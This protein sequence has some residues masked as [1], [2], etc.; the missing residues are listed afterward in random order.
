[1]EQIYVAQLAFKK[2][3]YPGG[4]DLI[5]LNPFNLSLVVTDRKR[6]GDLK[7]EMGLT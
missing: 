1:M 3:N 5:T 6:Q 7:C 2:G 4:L